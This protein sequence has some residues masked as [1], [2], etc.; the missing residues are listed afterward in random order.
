MIKKKKKKKKII[1][2][3]AEKANYKSLWT[4]TQLSFICHVAIRVRGA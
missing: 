1:K 2:Q 3:Q 4:S